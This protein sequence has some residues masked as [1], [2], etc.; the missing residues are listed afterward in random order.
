MALTTSSPAIF[1]AV[2][3]WQVF[4]WGIKI[5]KS[6]E[7]SETLKISSILLS[8]SVALGFAVFSFTIASFPE[9]F[10]VKED[11]RN[12]GANCRVLWHPGHVSRTLFSQD[13]CGFHDGIDGFLGFSY[14]GRFQGSPRNDRHGHVEYILQLRLTVIRCSSSWENLPITRIQ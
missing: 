9:E 4:V 13:P 12:G 2:V 1:F 5:S 6:G 11:S 14:V 8:Y 10:E 7:V 3:S